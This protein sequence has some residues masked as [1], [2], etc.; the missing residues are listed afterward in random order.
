MSVASLAPVLEASA[1]TLGCFGIHM[2]RRYAERL[3]AVLSVTALALALAVL[4]AFATL[5]AAPF[6][7]YAY[8]LQVSGL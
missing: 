8:A 4:T 1:F 2:F 7:D 5:N 3:T 6:D